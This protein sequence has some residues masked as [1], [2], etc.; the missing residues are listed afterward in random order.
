MSAMQ[1]VTVRVPAT[2]ANLG[3]AFDTAGIAFDLYNTFSFE[4]ADALTFEGFD[5]KFQNADNLA[6]VAYKSVCERLGVPSGVKITQ[7]AI[8]V[9]VSRG[10][11]SSATLIAAGAV[12]ANALHGSKLSDM[13]ILAVCTEI[14]GHPDNVAPALFGG[15]CVSLTDDGLPFSVCHRVSESICFTAVYPEFEVATRDARAV[16]PKEIDRHDAIY[17]LSR[18]ALLPH[19]FETGNFELLRAVTKDKLHEP[20]R[21]KLFRNIAEIEKAA[22]ECGAVSFIISGAGSTCLCISKEP[23]A[24]KLNEKTASLANGWKAYAIH[25]DKSGAVIEEKTHE[26]A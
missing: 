15:L 8:E 11:G 23:I 9:P 1:A 24:D 4:K 14:E 13:E 26:K 5:P 7:N 25:V 19:A 10:L 21:K 17:N 6:F 2:S 12:A 22:Y 3:S 18:A 20:Y 16:L